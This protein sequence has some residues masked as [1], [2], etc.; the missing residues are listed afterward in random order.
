[1]KT[2][3]FIPT[4]PIH[5]RHIE[6]ILNHY[7]NGTVVPDEIIISISQSHNLDDESKKL[8]KNKFPDVK[9]IE[10]SDSLQS[11]PNRQISKTACKGDIIIYQDSDDIPH[12]Q[13]VEII[14]YFFNNYDI[15]HLNHSY[16]RNES[17][18]FHISIP[19]IKFIDSERLYK[20]YFPNSILNECLKVHGAYGGGF[21]MGIHGGAIAIKREVL[22]VVEWKP[23]TH[24]FKNE[25]WL[26]GGLPP[27]MNHND[28][29][30]PG[31]EDYEFC[32]ETLF[33]LKK[34][35]LIDAKIYTYI[36]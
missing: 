27:I 28:P 4:I 3:L 23:K 10:H 8:I 33:K 35:I 24:L 18:D 9:I 12:R 19:D 31:A 20:S 29:R 11:G 21:D 16:T 30:I 5:F 2:S 26:R 14:K 13:R 6:N 32:M 36:R 34:S 17:N 25:E 7:Y 1:M 15:M 22:N